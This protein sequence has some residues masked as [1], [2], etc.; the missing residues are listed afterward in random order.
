[1]RFHIISLFPETI[2]KYLS[3]SILGRAK[4]QKLFSVDYFDPRK[5]TDDVRRTVDDRPY[6]GGPGMVMTATP[7]LKAVAAAKK[8]IKKGSRL[9]III[10]SPGGKEFTNAE[11]KSLSKKF[12]DIILI[13][14]RYEGIDGRVKKILKAT[15]YSIGSYI[16]TGGEV[17]AMALV[18]AVA[19]QIPGVL[20]AP[21]SVEEKRTSSHE[22]YTRPAILE[23]KGKKYRVPKL[24]LSGH[25]KNIESWKKKQKIKE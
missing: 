12:D 10:F 2:E 6:G 1:M 17:P 16:L 3:T 20:H 22:V 18:D 4:A 25:H 11:A 7:L 21:D 9:K 5:F 15:E 23:Y 13:S 19:R 14:G 24:L 8:K